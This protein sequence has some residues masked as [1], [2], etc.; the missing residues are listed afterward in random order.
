MPTMP[1]TALP[2]VRTYVRRR[3]EEAARDRR[4]RHQIRPAHLAWLAAPPTP[5]LQPLAPG[6]PP[7]GSAIELA[8]PG[9]DRVG[10]YSR[11]GGQSVIRLKAG[12][13]GLGRARI[14][15]ARR[16]VGEWVEGWG[17]ARA[18][19]VLAGWRAAACCGQPAQGAAREL[20]RRRRRAARRDMR[21]SSA[22]WCSERPAAV[23]VTMWSRR[24]MVRTPGSTRHSW[25]SRAR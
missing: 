10:E 7:I 16:E 21:R 14:R 1:P 20:R 3:E 12:R 2:G 15:V 6:G 9:D 4:H 22:T 5:P 23:A 24:P 17:P 25:W 11:D 18:S 19:L 8:R 13:P